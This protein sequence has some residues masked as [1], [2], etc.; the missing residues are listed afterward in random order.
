MYHVYRIQESNFE[1]GN[2]FLV[3][4]RLAGKKSKDSI[5]DII[6]IARKYGIQFQRVFILPEDKLIYKFNKNDIV[7]LRGGDGTLH[8][9]LSNLYSVS[10]NNFPYIAH[11][12]G[13][14]MCTVE[15]CIRVPQREKLIEK[16]QRYIKEKTIKFV[17]RPSIE[18]TF[19]E[20]KNIY[21]KLGFIFGA[22]LPAT[23]LRD[24]YSY[25]ETGP[26]TAV[27]TVFDYV[28]GILLMKK[29]VLKKFESK[30]VRLRSEEIGELVRNFHL[31][32]A[33]TIHSFGLNFSTFPKAPKYSDK[34]NFIGTSVNP[35]VITLMLPFIYFGILPPFSIN[36]VSQK[37]DISFDSSSDFTIDGDIYSAEE[38]TLK[39]GPTVRFVA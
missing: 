14:S 26:K 2:F 10:G 3:F 38:I 21:I 1:G 23:F 6:Y 25:P 8:H 33:S 30:R 5:E 11:L 4:N 32:G 35:F 27:K 29:Q 15:K 31:L 20:S 36:F 12:Y 34:F 24:Y 9:F 17:P 28:K 37:V 22:V 39:V 7:F 19:S 13:G 16:I 18:I